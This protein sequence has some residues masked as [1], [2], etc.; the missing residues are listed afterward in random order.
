MYSADDPFS[1][2][3]TCDALYVVGVTGVPTNH[4]YIPIHDLGQNYRY[5]S[6]LQTFTIYT[7]SDFPACSPN[8][9]D[10]LN[11]KASDGYTCA[12]ICAFLNSSGQKPE[13]SGFTWHTDTD[14]CWVKNGLNE[15]TSTPTHVPGSL[16]GIVH[17]YS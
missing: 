12:N 16:S 5:N 15:Y 4:T 3:P 8:I 11:Y 13:C 17:L 14:I 7:D 10:I 9:T 2:L 1:S 6:S